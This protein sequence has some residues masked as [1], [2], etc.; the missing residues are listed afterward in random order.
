[1]P[2]EAA[3]DQ[4]IHHLKLSCIKV[5]NLLDVR[6]MISVHCFLDL[7]LWV[8]QCCIPSEKMRNLLNFLPNWHKTLTQ[9]LSSVRF[10]VYKAFWPEPWYYTGTSIPHNNKYFFVQRAESGYTL[11]YA[12]EINFF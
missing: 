4:I 12:T 2:E 10:N 1:M 3:F 7:H 5:C 6:W 9:R 8:D 11:P